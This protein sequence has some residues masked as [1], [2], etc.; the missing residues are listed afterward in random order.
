MPGTFFRSATVLC[1]ASGSSRP[2]LRHSWDTGDPWADRERGSEHSMK[3]H[4]PIRRRLRCDTSLGR[5][6]HLEALG[7]PP[8]IRFHW[9]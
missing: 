2:P 8:A 7:Q 5:A 4:R 6:F 1:Q 3:P 9:R